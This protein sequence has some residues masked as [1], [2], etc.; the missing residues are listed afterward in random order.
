VARHPSENF[1]K[2]LITS[3]HSSS[4][5]D[6]WIK[7]MLSSLAFPVPDTNYLRDLRADLESRLPED[8]QPKNP[9]HRASKSFMR[10]EGIFNLH[11]PDKSSR[12]AQRILMHLRPREVI[13]SLILGRMET[14][15]I[16]KKVNSKFAEFFTAEGI[17]AYKHYYW[18]VDIVKVEDWNA[19][20]AESAE[21]RNNTV[22]IAKIGA[23]MALHKS[24]FQQQLESKSMLRAMQEALY[25]DFLEWKAAPSG[26]N[27]TRALTAIAKSAVLVD[28]QL[29][30]ADNAMKDS[31]KAFEQFRMETA[32]EKVKGVRDIAPS[33]NFTHSGAKLLDV[34][35]KEEE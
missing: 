19:L 30:Q 33:G 29:S 34:A 12:E 21:L 23:T 32:K 11:N 8:F 16:A 1:I 7:M 26:I 14:K 3:G 9:Y 35:R 10:K 18:N 13:Q 2:Y 24:G 20:M 4:G 17:Q 25:F 28:E 6:E 15:D 5:N 31:L 27:K 22:S